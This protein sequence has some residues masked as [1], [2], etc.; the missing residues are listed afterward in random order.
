V[1]GAAEVGMVRAL[2]ERGIRPDVVLGTSIG[3]LNGA[4]VAADPSPS[5]VDR[6]AELWRELGAG[7]VF[8]GSLPRR[9]GTLARTRTHLHG[10]GPLRRLFAQHAPAERIEQLAVPFECVAASI[11]RA[12]EH[13]F[14]TGPLADAV[15]ASCAV[16]GLFAPVRIGDE[17]F[18]D[19]GL[20]H[21]IPVG[22]AVTRGARTIYV[23]Q[24][25]RIERPL[26]PPRNPLEVGLVAF[27]IARRHRFAADMAALPADVAVHVLPTGSEPP[28]PRQE[29]DPRARRRSVGVG[30]R[31]ERAYEAGLA[32]LAGTG[33]S[34]GDA[35]AA[36]AGS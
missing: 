14:T 29:L 23:L 5:G 8:A 15:L 11:E 3:A 27:E 12:A 31:I 24:V 36:E 30:E 2:V 1:L 20:V 7:A 21:S 34:A 32:Y 10:R 35:D 18:Y 22:R 17:H 16:P 13:W 33:T 25:G 28:T 9:L 19:G 26:V 4:F 6:L